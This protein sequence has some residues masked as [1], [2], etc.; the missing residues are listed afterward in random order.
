MNISSLYKKQIPDHLN[1]ENILI[2]L[3]DSVTKVL[4]KATNGNVH[5]SGMVQKIQKTCLK[6]DIGCFVLFDGGFSGLVVLNFTAE[7]AMEIYSAYLLN[8][9]MSQS[10]LATVHT[11]DE[12]SNVMG[13]LMNQIVGDF[14]GRVQRALQISITQS[15]P[16]MLVLNKQVILSVDTN[17]DEPE[18]RRVSFYTSN[19]KA[20]YLELS[21]DKTEFIRV[22]DFEAEDVVDADELLDQTKANLNNASPA[23]APA[24]TYENDAEIDKLFD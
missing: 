7:A 20:F 14:T 19:N 23:K 6:P 5:Y 21:M 8:M 9:G 13:E 11:A 2:S 22:K 3:S 18:I 15:Q 1:T 17:L 10:D 24:A 16:N 12:V 4:N